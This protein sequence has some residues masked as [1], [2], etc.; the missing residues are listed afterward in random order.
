MSENVF[1][2]TGLGAGFTSLAF[3]LT[4]VYQSIYWAFF[5]T[6]DNAGT[7]IILIVA[8]VLPSSMCGAVFGPVLFSI[9]ASLIVMSRGGMASGPVNYAL[10]S[11][12]VSCV[13]LIPITIIT[14]SGII[15]LLPISLPLI[16]FAGS[17]VGFLVKRHPS[18]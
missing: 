3:G 13:L 1:L 7:F 2:A 14:G 18:P 10:L 8:T 16:A 12:V 5:D 11:L 15:S 4:A 9:V 6:T 17:L